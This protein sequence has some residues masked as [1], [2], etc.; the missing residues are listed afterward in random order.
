RNTLATA[1]S[2]LRELV[3]S[4]IWYTPRPRR[5]SARCLA[6]PFDRWANGLGFDYFY[7]FNAGDM[8]HWNPVLYENRD[9]VP[10]SSDPNYHLTAD[11]ADHAIAWT[12]RVK[13]ISPDRP[14]FL[15]V[16]PG[17]THSPHQVPKDWIDK[18]RGK[19]DLGWDRYCEETF[20][21]QKE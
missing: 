11:I 6:G 12:R 3:V 20:V 17:A 10:A 16:A 8:N 15:Y 19:F 4:I 21:R 2:N 9:L 13:G 7:G 14:I 1:M 5:A 18:F